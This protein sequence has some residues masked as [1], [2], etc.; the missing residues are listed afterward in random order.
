MDCSR[1]EAALYALVR[2]ALWGTLPTDLSPL[3]L[4]KGEWSEVHALCGSQTVTALTA[5]AFEL[6]PCEALPPDALL[7][8]WLAEAERTERQGA[9]MDE[10][11]AALCGALEA[12]GLQPV[13]LKGQGVS[14]LYD[15]P[16]QREAGDIDL[17]FPLEGHR[18]RAEQWLEHEGAALE[19]QP[20]GSA[21][22]TWRGVEVELHPYL[23]DLS[24]PA[25]RRH[26]RR[27]ERHDGFATIPF[28]DGQSLHV[29][30]PTLCL[31]LLSTHILKHAMGHGV[32][33]RQLCDMAMALRRWSGRESSAVFADMSHR[34]GLQRWTELLCSF[35]VLR[36][37]LPEGS[38]PA[39]VTLCD[40]APLE[41]IVMA[42]GNFG[43]M[44]RKAAS[45]S[46]LIRKTDTARAFLVHS[47][48]SLRY[49][50]KEAVWTV[51]RLFCGQ[52]KC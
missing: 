52:S 24:A 40:C 21:Y 12:E 22:C 1:V 7:M 34:L 6:L 32:G 38:V 47:G 50:P 49:A 13:V 46:V 20:D 29:P 33:L 36:L 25:H 19:R 9:K 23:F 15:A 48:F 18:Q 5:A 8:R 31:L 26:L 4:S 42:G 16:H 2:T 37:G 3:R 43:F 39:G 51:L 30:S 44:R 14:R 27:M 35:L 28:T 41:R 17:Y 11:V 45:S 10:V